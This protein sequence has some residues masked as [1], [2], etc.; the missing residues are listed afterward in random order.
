M[1]IIG[2]NVNVVLFIV[3][4]IESVDLIV[5]YVGGLVVCGGSFGVLGMVSV[6]DMF[7]S[8]INY[9]L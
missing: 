8:I 9:I 3:I 2:S 1:V 7:F 6:M 5:F 4:I